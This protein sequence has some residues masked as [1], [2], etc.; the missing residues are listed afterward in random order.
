[1]QIQD[2]QAFRSYAAARQPRSR[3]YVKRDKQTRRPKEANNPRVALWSGRAR[4]ASAVAACHQGL[5]G[6]GDPGNRAGVGYLRGNNHRHGGSL[7]FVPRSCP[8]A[9]RVVEI[10]PRTNCKTDPSTPPAPRQ[11][12][13]CRHRV[14]GSRC[15][16]TPRL[17]Y[18]RRTTKI[19]QIH[20]HLCFRL[21]ILEGH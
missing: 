14:G 8:P 13:R 17:M 11:S 9:S 7:C 3:H 20:N 16:K 1:M 6:K 18:L 12:K 10:G 15:N 19:I 2:A 21:Q 5:P 4:V